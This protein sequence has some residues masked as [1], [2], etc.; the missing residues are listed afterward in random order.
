MRA[1]QILFIIRFS[2][3]EKNNNK[4]QMDG[5]W[6][7]QENFSRQQT[8]KSRML[9]SWHPSIYLYIHLSIYSSIWHCERCTLCVRFQSLW[10][11]LGGFGT[12]PNVCLSVHCTQTHKQ[13]KN[14][15]KLSAPDA[16]QLCVHEEQRALASFTQ[17]P[18]SEQWTHL[19]TQ[20]DRTRQTK[21]EKV[22]GEKMKGKEYTNKRYTSNFLKLI[23]QQIASQSTKYSWR[24]WERNLAHSCTLS[25]KFAYSVAQNFLYTSQW[26]K[27]AVKTKNIL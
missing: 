12:P 26:F 16:L 24:K 25:N 15:S 1:Q 10:R 7:K 13:P 4:N 19:L 11:R 18:V 3:E 20:S 21:G 9:Q 22:G 2:E 8:T 5:K 27:I 23:N 14:K 17:I 6:K